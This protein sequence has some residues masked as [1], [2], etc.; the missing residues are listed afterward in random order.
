MANTAQLWAQHLAE[1]GGLEHSSS[2][3]YGENLIYSS[4]ILTGYDLTQLWYYEI[5]YYSFVNPGFSTQTGNFTQLVWAN[6]REMGVG[7]A[8]SSDGTTYYVA[9]YSPPGNILGAFD[10]N[11]KH[12]RENILDGRPRR[13]KSPSSDPLNEIGKVDKT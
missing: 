9:R 1:T 7:K 5:K 4:D 8:T 2:D 11:V 13:K 10:T 12:P 3:I 6:S